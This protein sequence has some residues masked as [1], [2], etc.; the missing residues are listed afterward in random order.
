MAKEYPLLI[1]HSAKGNKRLHNVKEVA[2]FI[3]KHGLYSDVTVTFEDNSPLL[4]TYGFY[5]NKINDMEYS[6]E[7]LKVLVPMQEAVF[8]V[9]DDTEDIDEDSDPNFEMEM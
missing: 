1:G 3:M 7:L 2:D 9:D 5:L 6:E 8:D 4:D